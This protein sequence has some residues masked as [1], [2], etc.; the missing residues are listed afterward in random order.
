LA[1]LSFKG[2][3]A[4]VSF[5]ASISNKSAKTEQNAILTFGKIFS[6]VEHYYRPRNKCA[7]D[8]AAAQRTEINLCSNI[9]SEI[10][11]NS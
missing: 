1:I 11:K 7:M 4:R 10:K 2:T 5:Q 3:S 9:H 8:P 6:L